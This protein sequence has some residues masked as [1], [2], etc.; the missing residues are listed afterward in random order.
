MIIEGSV[1]NWAFGIQI[2]SIFK[3]SLPRGNAA[4]DNGMKYTVA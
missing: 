2:V 1:R 4:M 3:K